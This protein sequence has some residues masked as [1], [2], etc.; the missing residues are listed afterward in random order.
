MPTT[1]STA[2]ATMH[3]RDLDDVYHITPLLITH[4]SNRTS[5]SSS[6]SSSNSSS[7]SSSSSNSNN[8]SSYVIAVVSCHFDC[9]FYCYCYCCRRRLRNNN[10]GLL[11]PICST[12][13]PLLLSVYGVFRTALAPIGVVVLI[14]QLAFGDGFGCVVVGVRH[15]FVSCKVP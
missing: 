3:G 8:S 15:C 4:S 10:T 14:Q 2:T 5:S 7:S 11:G 13:I 12:H 9:Y 6:Y 1:T